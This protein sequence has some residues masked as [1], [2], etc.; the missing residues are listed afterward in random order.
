M[1]SRNPWRRVGRKT[2]YENPWIRIHHDDVIRPDGQP[3]I[4]GVVDFRNIAVGVVVL[5]AHE[6]MLLVGQFRYTLDAYSWEIPEGGVPPDELPLDGA[7][8]ELAEETG[9]RAA[10][11]RPL[12]RLA[13]SNSVTN[14]IGRLFVA[15]ELT[16]GTAQPDGTEVLSSRW[17]TISEAVT[18]VDRGEI[19]DAMSQVAIL[20]IALA[21]SSPGDAG[22]RPS[23]AAGRNRKR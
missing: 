15:R 20:R 13:T 2:V 14:E 4:Y 9:Y 8:R 16:P 12:C 10:D 11:W 19:T 1:T 5:D 21:Q 7:K 3:G 17:V 22:E 23:S 6:R 18:M